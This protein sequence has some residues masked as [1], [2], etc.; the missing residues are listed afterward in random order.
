M[1]VLSPTRPRARLKLAAV[2]GAFAAIGLLTAAPAMAAAKPAT[3]KA[4]TIDC[5]GDTVVGHV[6][7]QN[8]G[9]D[10]AKITLY[11][12]VGSGP[13]TV[14]S[15]TTVKTEP[16]MFEIGYN[17][18]V[19]KHKTVYR[20]L[21]EVGASSKWS[22]RIHDNTCQPPAEVPEAGMALAVPIA[23][24]LAGG[25]AWWFHRRRSLAG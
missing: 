9:N 6:G 7:I 22:Q 24:G 10:T 13:F 12:R 8:P 14:I 2:A 16:D 5:I 4:V 15:S 1:N 3:V 17:F 20:V 19:A 25:A 11:G 18:T 23:M 21:A